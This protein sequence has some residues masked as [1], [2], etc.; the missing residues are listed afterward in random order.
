M[1]I[2]K[3][4]LNIRWADIDANRHLRHSVYYDFAAAM[5]MNILNSKGLTTEKLI[6]YHIGPI[7]FREEA[8]FKR[9]VKLEDKV[10]IDV[11]LSKCMPDYSR[12]SLRHNITKPDGSVCT[13]I[14]VDGAWMDLEKRK[15]TTP[16]E[17]IQGIFAGFPKSPDFEWL[18]PKP[19]RA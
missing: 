1:D 17:F 4:P 13:I 10:E 6:E 2:Y 12:W 15:L 19:A 7:L 3:A 9:E 14:T 8:L 16:N 18:V 5:R 11:Q